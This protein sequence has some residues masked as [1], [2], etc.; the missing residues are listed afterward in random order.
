[1]KL[2]LYF[3][4][5]CTARCDHCITFA[6]PKVTRKMSLESAQRV[7]EMASRTPGLDGICFTGG[8]NL[9]HRSEMLTLV[10][11]CT[12]YGLRSEI[13][14]NGFWATNRKAALAFLE[15]FREAGLERIHISI[16]RYHL[17]YVPSRRVHCA[18]DAIKDCGFMRE[19]ACVIDRHYGVD[20]VLRYAEVMA[21][22]NLDPDDWDEESAQRLV[23]GLRPSWPEELRDLLGLYGFHEPDVVWI[24]EVVAIKK[25]LATKGAI[26]LAHHFYRTKILLQYQTLATEGRGRQLAA[27]VA[28]VGT[29]DAPDEVCD[30]VG[31]TPTI[32]PEGDM[33]PCCSSWVNLPGQR[34]ATIDG[35]DTTRFL[36]IMERDPVVLFM[37]YQ[38]PRALVKF[39]R[40]KGHDLP[41]AYTHPCH[42]CGTT[43]ERYT[44]A[45]LLEHIEAFYEEYPWRQVFTVRGIQLMPFAS[46]S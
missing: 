6:G 3:T 12:R 24:D 25:L 31:N 30:S 20:K 34:L 45:E 46:D 18:L 17:P 21:D 33:F 27:H 44:R 5:A 41:E 32:T 13:I 26:A 16:D 37:R 40:D 23:D 7:L 22:L 38:G 4:L 28:A 36:E 1:M 9:I 15:P 35:A 43:L 8:E 14:S 19:I 2:A 29:N 11:D 42:F 10:R 39:L